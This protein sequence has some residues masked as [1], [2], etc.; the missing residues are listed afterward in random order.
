MGAM[1]RLEVP[2]PVWRFPFPLL[3]ETHQESL[4]P[5]CGLLNTYEDMATLVKNSKIQDG[6]ML[7]HVNCVRSQLS[8]G[9]EDVAGSGCLSVVSERPPDVQTNMCSSFFPPFVAAYSALS[10][11]ADILDCKRKSM[12]NMLSK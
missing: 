11:V 8:I 10:Q 6:P 9:V 7:H 3:E 4:N 12:P 1:Y 5:P 2:I